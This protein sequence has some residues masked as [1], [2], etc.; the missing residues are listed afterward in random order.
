[1]NWF[2]GHFCSIQIQSRKA[3]F[4]W[5]RTSDS[6]M[7][8]CYYLFPNFLRKC[9]FFLLNFSFVSIFIVNKSSDNALPKLSFSNQNC[10]INLHKDPLTASLYLHHNASANS[11]QINIFRV[12]DKIEN[13]SWKCFSL[14]CEK[15]HIN[16][17]PCW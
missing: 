5:N 9:S 8:N 7:T 3:I 4:L 15:L 6:R 1:M 11:T 2:E 12:I 17:D 13:W 14:N 16:G 10:P